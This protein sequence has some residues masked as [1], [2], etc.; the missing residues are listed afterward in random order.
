MW[1][2]TLLLLA[3]LCLIRGELRRRLSIKNLQLD[4]T[5]GFYLGGDTATATF[6]VSDETESNVFCIWY[7]GAGKPVDGCDGTQKKLTAYA[8]HK[9]RSTCKLTSTNFGQSSVECQSIDTSNNNAIEHKEFDVVM[10]TAGGI[11]TESDDKGPPETDDKSVPDPSSDDPGKGP[12]PQ[13]DDAPAP[14]PGPTNHH[15]DDDYAV[16]YAP[17]E[18]VQPGPGPQPAPS[19]D[20]GP[21]SFDD[22]G[23]PAPIPKPAP[24]PDGPV[25]EDDVAPH[26]GPVPGPLD[27]KDADDDDWHPPTE[28]PT[29]DISVTLTVSMT[30]SGVSK[31]SWD[32]DTSSYNSAWA[33][34]MVRTI[35]SYYITQ[36]NI[37]NIGVKAGDSSDGTDRV[38]VTGTVKANDPTDTAD[39]VYSR[40][41]DAV[42]NGIFTYLLDE[43]ARLINAWDLQSS[44][45]E[46]VKRVTTSASVSSVEEMFDEAEAAA[47]AEKAQDEMDQAEA[48]AEADKVEDAAEKAQ[49]NINDAEAAAEADKAAAGGSSDSSPEEDGT[50]APGKDT[51]TSSQSSSSKASENELGAGAIIGIVAGCV[52]AIVLAGLSYK[53][54]CRARK[55]EP[56]VTAMGITPPSH[57]PVT[58][59]NPMV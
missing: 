47:K 34:A 22:D 53:M 10:S 17:T 19:P 46:S 35:T 54:M 23:G 37:V 6:S 14:A 26:P 25:I 7:D 13:D 32:K 27:P 30:I 18:K 33:L 45:A 28:G 8:P 3:C 44:K 2:S 20:P 16:T 42:G 51:G 56:N 55:Q 12:K 11:F 41:E 29:S 21:M 9:Y 31:A 39:S 50:T 49:Q 36:S 59:E 48:A 15:F 58:V 52:A 43:E 5:Q 57:V 24:G 4:A 38:V 1:V 40:V